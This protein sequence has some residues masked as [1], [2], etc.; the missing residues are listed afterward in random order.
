MGKTFGA[1]GLVG[2]LADSEPTFGK[3]TSSVSG[4]CEIGL[5]CMY[6]SPL[7]RAR[8]Q[9]PS[10]A[11]SEASFASPDPVDTSMTEDVVVRSTSSTVTVVGISGRPETISKV[12]R[13]SAPSAPIASSAGRAT[14]SDTTGIFIS[15][16]PGDGR[17]RRPSTQFSNRAGR[18]STCARQR[19]VRRHGLAS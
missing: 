14:R 4:D 1:I 7:C 12:V 6:L 17:E 13:N 19:R 16:P 8:A 2:G 15:Q 9:R 18:L 5:A 3:V 10:S 11:A